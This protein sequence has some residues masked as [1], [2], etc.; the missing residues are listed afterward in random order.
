MWFEKW[1]KGIYSQ[2]YIAGLDEQWKLL[3]RVVE[4]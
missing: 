4:Y 2:E 3:M 1:K